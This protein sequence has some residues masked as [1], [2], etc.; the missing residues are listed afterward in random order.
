MPIV[1]EETQLVAT[2]NMLPA[3]DLAEN[4]GDGWESQ[5]EED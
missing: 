2:M 3:G 4:E 1:S 5:L